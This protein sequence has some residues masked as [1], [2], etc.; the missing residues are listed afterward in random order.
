M[1]DRTIVDWYNFCREVLTVV[2]IDRREQIGG[3][4][5]TVEIDESKFGKRNYHRG[6]RVE[7]TWVF[8]GVERESGKLFMVPVEKRDS[9]TLIPLIKEWILPGTT[10]IS[11]CWR[12]YTCLKDEDFEHL[13]VN[14][15]INFKDPDTGA[16]TNTIEGAWLHAKRSLPKYGTKNHF[17]TGYL[18]AHMWRR[19]VATQG[20]DPF[21]SF[22]DEVKR[23]YRPDEWNVVGAVGH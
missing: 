15:S 10:I 8:G 3:P 18:A 22:L 14:H 6:H 21:L 1:S 2:C 12:A 4:G 16:H 17:M 5:T 13:T 11:D 20:G 19:R 7:G 23:V 9:A